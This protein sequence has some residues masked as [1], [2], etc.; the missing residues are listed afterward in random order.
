MLSVAK[1]EFAKLGNHAPPLLA[2]TSDIIK[3]GRRHG[4]PAHH[5]VTIRTSAAAHRLCTQTTV[6]FSLYLIDSAS[7]AVRLSLIQKPVET[8][9]GDASAGVATLASIIVHFLPS[10]LSMYPQKGRHFLCAVFPRSGDHAP[11]SNA[12]KHPLHDVPPLNFKL[13]CGRSANFFSSPGSMYNPRASLPNCLG[14][15]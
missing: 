8:R 5:R 9:D 11:T 6:S 3:V 7:I 2:C 12:G 4:G 13:R 14:A 1:P 10:G 15:I